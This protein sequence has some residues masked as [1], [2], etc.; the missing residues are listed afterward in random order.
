MFFLV[1][2]VIDAAAQRH[3]IGLLIDHVFLKTGDHISGIIA[4][5]TGIDLFGLDPVR[6]KAVYHQTAITYGRPAKIGYGV[7]QERD[8]LARFYQ[9]PGMKIGNQGKGERP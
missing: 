2:N 1:P 5:D 3:P 8:L 6:L 9:Y 7:A 4:E